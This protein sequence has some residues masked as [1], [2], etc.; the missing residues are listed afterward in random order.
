MIN[1][2][3]FEVFLRYVIFFFLCWSGKIQENILE[4]KMY[5]SINSRKIKQIQKKKERKKMITSF[6][7]LDFWKV[8]QNISDFVV[9]TSL[10]ISR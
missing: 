10:L 7:I 5:M 4:N 9:L 6:C 2:S 1:V 3:P 8:E